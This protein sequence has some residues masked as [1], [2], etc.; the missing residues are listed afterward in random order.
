MLIIAYDVVVC[1]IAAT[2]GK[3]DA[4]RGLAISTVP[5]DYIVPDGVIIGFFSRIA[6]GNMNSKAGVVVNLG[7]INQIVISFDI[8]A[9]PT[10]WF[11]R[12]TIVI[13]SSNDF[14]KASLS[15]DHSYVVETIPPFTV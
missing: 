12:T 15:V 14:N 5:I 3:D 6:A 4:C 10:L 9:I 2:G 8:E 7:T 1:D 11:C 13:F